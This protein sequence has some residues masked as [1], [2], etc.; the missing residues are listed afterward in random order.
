M[1]AQTPMYKFHVFIY[2]NDNISSGEFTN[3]LT[4]IYAPKAASFV[5]GIVS[6]NTVL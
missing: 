2:R 1:A 3:H 6:S 4:N 5:K